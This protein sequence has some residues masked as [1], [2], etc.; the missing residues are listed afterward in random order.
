MVRARGCGDR[1]SLGAALPLDPRLR[2]ALCASLRAA[3]SRPRNR[4]GPGTHPPDPLLASTRA[5]AGRRM[6]SRASPPRAAPAA[7]RVTYRQLRALAV[8]LALALAA[9]IAAL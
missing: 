7:H 9:H 4:P 5:A 2:I 3:A 6:N 1:G 8:C